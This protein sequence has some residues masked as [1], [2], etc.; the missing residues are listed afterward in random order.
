MSLLMDALRRAESSKQEAARAAASA[1]QPP[2]GLTLEPLGAEP[3]P[4]ATNSLPDLA[5]HIDALDAD[6]AATSNAQ[7]AIASNAN[8]T[9]SQARPMAANFPQTASEEA[10]QAAARNLFAAKQVAPPSRKPMW[11]GLGLL[12]LA[13]LGI[14]A[15]VW[16]QTQ[17]LSVN[18]LTRAGS[19][20]PASAP[21]TPPS[22]PLNANTAPRPAPD[23][24]VN[25]PQIPAST[26]TNAFPEA[27]PG[28][29]QFPAAERAAPPAEPR[30]ANGNIRFSRTRLEVDP[31]LQSG[32]IKLQANQLDPARRD[33]E[34]ALR[35]DPNNIDA[36]LALAAIAQRQGQSAD[37]ERYLQRAQEADPRD[38]AVLAAAMGNAPGSD[39]TPSESRLKTLLAAQPE[40]GPLNFA[41][42]NLYARQGRWP[43]AQ[44]LFFNAVAADSDNPDYLFN[45]A[46][47]LDQIRQAKLAAQH[48][49]LAL[50]AA[51][52]RPAAFDRES[53][54]LRLNELQ[55]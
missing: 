28:R 24:A 10:L 2:A 29:P 8:D 5:L 25:L 32:Y 42:G 33:Y 43:E 30:L 11:I 39:P 48:Y 54:R 46:V 26:A 12:G 14:G 21:S 49:R 37:A 20:P 18:T 53:V 55:P 51:Q 22:L 16:Y 9:A 36:L 40:S 7:A 50:E 3:P 1:E 34:A 31:H 17:A 27:F 6:L 23:P 47:S 44:Q 4:Q 19:L 52:K 35:A 38:P 45:L 15:Y 41:L 13:L